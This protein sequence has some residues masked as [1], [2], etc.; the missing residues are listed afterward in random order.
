M[1]QTQFRIL[2]TADIADLERFL[3]R[4]P[5]TSMFLRSNL[6]HAGIVD[7]GM[8]Y[9]GTYVGQFKGR[10]LTGVAA[11][12][13]NG[14]MVFQCEPGDAAAI[15]AET[16]A[17]ALPRACRGLVGPRAI[18]AP[19]IEL[20]PFSLRRAKLASRQDLYALD[21]ANLPDETTMVARVRPAATKDRET[22]AAWRHDYLC[23][24]LNESPGEA[25]RKQAYEEIGRAIDEG[26]AFVLAMADNLMAYSGF[27]ATLPDTVQVGGVYCPPGER[28]LGYGRA[29]THGAL[30]A[31]RKSGVKRAILFTAEDNIPAK[32]CYE[33]LGF[34]RVGDYAIVIY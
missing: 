20:P 12:Y 21:I 24:T 33:S 6:R 11:L 26:R 22:L 13:W 23:E 14:N 34:K 8:P 1:Q 19:V 4:A 29:A 31:A 3:E 7:K 17:A 28:G 25:T 5:D 32:R 18:L 30:L 9:Q 2:G 16:L 27:N 10:D 15:A